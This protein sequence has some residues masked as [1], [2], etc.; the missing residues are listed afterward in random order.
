MAGSIIVAT[1]G[2]VG[3]F[4]TKHS[5]AWTA[6][7]GGVV[8]GNPTTIRSGYLL[9]AKFIPGTAGNQPTDLYDVTLLDSD[10]VDI[11][12]GFGAARSNSVAQIVPTL[13]GQGASQRQI[14]W[15][16][17]GVVT[18]MVVSAGNAKTGTLILYV[19]P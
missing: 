16:E 11:L 18:P 19:G 12:R 9:Q 4:V 10:G 6:S 15:I 8:S 2:D 17:G 13:D 14:G 5:I 7:A 3:G 1:T